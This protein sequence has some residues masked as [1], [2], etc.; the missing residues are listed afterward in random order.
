MGRWVRQEDGAYSQPD[1]PRVTKTLVGA[2]ANLTDPEWPQ[3]PL[4]MLVAGWGLRS[5]E[6]RSPGEP[7]N[8]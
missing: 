8:P 3:V 6:V 1:W 7:I 4:L 5:L 2:A